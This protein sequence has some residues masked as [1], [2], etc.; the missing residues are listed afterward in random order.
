MI[1]T[2]YPQVGYG[3]SNVTCDSYYQA[4]VPSGPGISWSTMHDSG[5]GQIDIQPDNILLF[6]GWATG[7]GYVSMA[8][9]SFTFDTS[10]IPVG[11]T[12]NS[13]ALQ[14]YVTTKNLGGYTHTPAF[15]IFG[16][17]PISD[18]NVV[19][20]DWSHY[21][22]IPFATAITFASLATYAYNTWTF[23]AAGLAAIN[24]GGVTRLCIR[25]SNYD[26]PNIEPPMHY[27]DTWGVDMYAVDAG[28]STRP[29]LTIDY[30]PPVTFIPKIA[31]IF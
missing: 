26:A 17:S 5:G 10:S 27:W 7:S 14:L 20:A 30:T 18:N 2:Q 3:G 1:L 29:I 6:V 24:A 9:S 16:F 19:G 13:V 12:I 15:N 31:F 21:G 4:L 8:R 22:T 25:E 28:T 23:I 11:S